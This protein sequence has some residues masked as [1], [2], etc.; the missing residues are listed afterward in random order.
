MRTKSKFVK[1]LLIYLVI[2]SIFVSSV[3]AHEFDPKRYWNDIYFHSSMNKHIVRLRVNINNV[4]NSVYNR[5]LRDAINDWEVLDDGYCDI[6]VTTASNSKIMVY[7][8]YPS[9]Y[10]QNAYAVTTSTLSSASIWYYPNGITGSVIYQSCKKITKASIYA[11]IT[12]QRQDDFN[13]GDIAKTWVHE[14]GHVMGLNETTGNT[15]SV[16]KQ[17]QG[18]TLGW[19]NYWQPQTHDITDLAR[20]HRVSWGGSAYE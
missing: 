19:S 18:S 17:G 6:Q 9:T 3:K 7:D 12:R 2:I 5:K 1:V 15:R 4:F 14:L 13:E 10:N 11:N 20:Y 8:T 16:M